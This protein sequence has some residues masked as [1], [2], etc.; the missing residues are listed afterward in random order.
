MGA[1]EFQT[2]FFNGLVPQ[3]LVEHRKGISTFAEDL[4]CRLET[5]NVACKGGSAQGSRIMRR[6]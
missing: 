2:P 3:L 4:F 5:S 1:L 6:N